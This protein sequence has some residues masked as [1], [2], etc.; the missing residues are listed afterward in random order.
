MNPPMNDDP[1]RAFA[2]SVVARLREA[3]H[4]AYWAG[5]CV[6]DLLLGLE[7]TDYD[8][9]TDAR[10]EQIVRLFRRTIGVGA[11]F[12]VIKVLGPAGAGDVEVATFRS[13]GAYLDGRHPEA[14]T[15]STAEFDASRRDFTINGMFLDPADGRV[16]DFV[17][18]QADL[19]DRVLRAIGDA[20]ARFAE[21]KL[22]L[23]RA[24]RFAARFVLTIDPETRRAVEAMAPQVTTV[25]AERIAQELRR[26]LVHPTRSASMATAADV[27]LIAAI[28]PNLDTH[29]PSWP[30][31]LRILESLPDDPSFPL[32]FAVF[33]REAGR[34]RAA[35]HAARLKLSNAERDRIAWLVDHR[36]ALD[37]PAHLPR[38][39]LKRLL[40]SEGI[41]DLLA[42]RRA[43]ALAT[44]G[45]LGPVTYSEDYLR[46]EPDGP[47][48]PPPLLTGHDLARHGLRPGPLFATL[49]EFVRDAQL[50]GTISTRDE[51][52]ALADRLAQPPQVP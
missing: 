4:E 40:A 6:R 22:R 42:L 8:V 7:P 34:D 13:D 21:D 44:D 39:R 48:D 30:A 52:L 17:N 37:D 16:I 12:G 10:P 45:D 11:S 33:L 25:S 3:G 31:T 1:R 19:R 38:H 50:D 41:A 24:V 26:M 51:A 29:A 32:A 47:I 18:G 23:L 20:S 27:G 49:L 9:A 46:T 14:V 43:E 35:A 36:R 5:G 28:F 15:F 2:A